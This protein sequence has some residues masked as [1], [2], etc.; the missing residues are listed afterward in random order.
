M[1]RNLRFHRKKL[2]GLSA[3]VVLTAMVFFAPALVSLQSAPGP[4]A[5][6]KPACA[7]LQGR[8]GD[9]QSRPVAGV[10]VRIK[11]KQ[12]GAEL[13]AV[14][15]SSGNYRFSALPA[16][17]FS[18]SAEASGQGSTDSVPLTLRANESRVLD[19]TLKTASSKNST[20]S[21][22]EF[23][24]DVH[25][26]VAGVTDTTNLGGH[27]SDVVVRNREAVAK[28]A[29]ALR[30][31]PAG[32]L[33]SSPTHEDEKSLRLEAMNHPENFAANYEL[34]KWLTD[35]AKPQEAIA[36]FEKAARLQPANFDNAFALA[37][38]Y[39]RAG[40][41]ARA[42]SSVAALLA[43]PNQ[44][45]SRTA[46]LHH[47]LGDIEE[48]SN[49]PLQALQEYAEAARLNPSES[50][51][52]D[53]ASELLIHHAAEPAIEVFTK[54]NRLFPRST[55]ILVGLGAAWY[56]QGSYERAVES[57]CQASELNPQDPNPYLL[58]GKMQAAE[59]APLPKVKE[60][61]TEFVK[62]QPQNPL[63]NYYYAVSLWKGRKSPDDRA[64]LEQV[65]TLLEKAVQLDPGLAKASLELG[66]VYAE[67]K[68][69]Q[70]AI[71]WYQRAIA[72]DPSLEQAH[73]RLAQ[74]Y[75]QSGDTEKARLELQLYEKISREKEQEVE[76]QH[77]EIQQ[78]V[79][80]LR[81]E[82]PQS[83]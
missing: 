6:E 67:Q 16:G 51:L 80:R 54:G 61:L 38:A 79:Y 41:N 42:R 35:A 57:L 78:F 77:H 23:S 36:F 7:T 18:V 12:S 55:R 17:A 26:T 45:P 22:P 63:A 3:P 43:E 70:Q 52:F 49:H 32:D 14:T 47:F 13:S 11:A 28:Q 74:A 21:Q 5:D 68:D 69:S 83:Q 40:N 71:L 58:L 62:L 1:A 53:W 56:S 33:A 30:Q 48:A 34:G 81:D 75:R 64:E 60:R 9:S 27:G 73:Y 76:R 15:D 31:N 44:P 24:D 2:A 10:T 19:L 37:L 46:D 72:A 65:K 25:F 82:S 59:S 39:E 20:G 8:V 66:S 4:Q 50:N 29:A